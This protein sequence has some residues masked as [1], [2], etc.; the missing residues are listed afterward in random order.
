VL[1]AAITLAFHRFCGM[2]TMANVSRASRVVAVSAA[3]AFAIVA[4]AHA[5]TSG[6]RNCTALHARYPHGVGRVGA[7]DHTS[8]G[9]PVT[10]F[11]RSNVLYLANRGLDRDKDGV[12]REK[13]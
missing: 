1:L 10:D 6:Y 12:A 5:G 3:L 13:H 2:D 8:S 9:D 4:A 11:R 7:H